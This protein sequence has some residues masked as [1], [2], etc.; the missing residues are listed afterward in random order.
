MKIASSDL[1]LGSTH[2]ASARREQS[3]SLFAWNG[4][5]RPENGRDQASPPAAILRLSDAARGRSNATPAPPPAPLAPSVGDGVSEADAIDTA[6]EAVANDPFLQLVKSMVEMLTG[7]PV[8][9]FAAS[10]LS[11]QFEA[12]GSTTASTAATTPGRAAGFGLEYDFHSVYEETEVTRFTAAG[13]IRT[14]D[15]KEI[16]FR[17]DL[18][19][20]RHYREETNVSIRAGDAVRKDPLVLNFGGTAAQLSSQRFRFDLD[21]DG[22]AEELPLFSSGSGYLALDRNGN[23]RIDSGTEL[24]GP[25]TNSGFAE[26]ARLDADGNGWIDENDPAFA[27]LQVWSP[28]ADG[29]GRLASLKEMGVGALALAAAA[30]PFELRDRDNAD[31]GGIRA[32]GLW[33]GEDGRAGSL[34]EIDLTV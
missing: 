30:T 14:T 33:L 9:V 31:L 5:S 11:R 32:S 29:G 25:A 3:E 6:A 34:Q 16:S 20:S 23:G 12:S 2:A 7:R 8:R 28:T 17:L 4:P 21:G 19:M 13:V 10:E 15:G 24:F 18:T 27:R 26:L 22:R 1:F